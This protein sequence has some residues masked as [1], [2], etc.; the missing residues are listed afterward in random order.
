MTSLKIMSEAIVELSKIYTIMNMCIAQCKLHADS[1]TQYCN[2]NA[3]TPLRR[4]KTSSP[5]LPTCIFFWLMVGWETH[6]PPYCHEASEP[7][8][9]IDK[10]WEICLSAHHEYTKKANDWTSHVSAEVVSVVA[11]ICVEVSS[12]SCSHAS[13]HSSHKKAPRKHL[14]VRPAFTLILAISQE[15]A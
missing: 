12:H 1:A 13:S 7:K 11:W 3:T 5:P 15:T 14:L 9:K 8:R 4:Q 2:E 10:G 6:F